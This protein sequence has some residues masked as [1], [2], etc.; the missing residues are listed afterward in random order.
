[1][2]AAAIATSLVMAS[3]AVAQEAGVPPPP[4]ERLLA[5]GRN[6]VVSYLMQA[7]GLSEADAQE[8]L[9]VQNEVMELA[10]RLEKENDP[11]YADIWIEHQPATR[12]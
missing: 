12:L 4:S 6:P 9:A 3:A 8:R 7:Y 1:M 5:G 10:G 2:I 11:A